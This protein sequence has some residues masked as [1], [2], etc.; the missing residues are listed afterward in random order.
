MLAQAA[1]GFAQPAEIDDS[2]RPGLLGRGGETAS[3]ASVFFCALLSRDDHRVDQVEGRATSLHGV[4]ESHALGR[5]AA[6][7]LHSVV[8]GPWS[9]LEFSRFARQTTNAVARLKQPGPLDGRRCNRSP[10]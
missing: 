4:E 8:M 7:Q 1:A 6:D 2:S 3:E 9:P 5:I 10:R